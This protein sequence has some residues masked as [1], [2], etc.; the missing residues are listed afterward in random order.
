MTSQRKQGTSVLSDAR[1]QLAINLFNTQDWYAAHDAF[2]ELWHESLGEER[3]LLQGIIQIA[4]AEHHLG[5]G[6][7]R[8][9]L[10]LMA[11]GLNRLRSSPPHQPGFDLQALEVIV[12]ARL[13]GLQTGQ[14]L[15][16]IPVPVLV[17]TTPDKD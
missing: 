15:V 12:R 13:T 8:G 7:H 14:S 16:D 3:V 4:V 10:L 11:E 6:N 5:G 2:E 9:A 1:Y 17:R